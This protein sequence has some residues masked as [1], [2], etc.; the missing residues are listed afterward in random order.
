VAQSIAPVSATST[1]TGAGVDMQGYGAALISFSTGV[2]TTANST[3]KLTV[4]LQ[5]DDDVAF[6]TV[7]TV[8]AADMIGT[9]PTINDSATQASKT[10]TFGYIGKKR[11]IR[12]LATVAASFSGLIGANVTRGFPRHT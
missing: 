10:F 6:G 7:G 12:V 3:D 8:A 2:L 9:P 1:K 11:Y 5:E 4:T